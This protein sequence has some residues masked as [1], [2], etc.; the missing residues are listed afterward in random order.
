MSNLAGAVAKLGEREA[1]TTRL[2]EAVVIYQELLQ[3]YPGNGMPLVWA[4]TQ[5][6]FGTALTKLA[7]REGGT[8]RLV[9]ADRRLSRR[10][11]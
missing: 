5:N 9:E 4:A 2:Q 3:G 6:N 7:E 10:A 1:G 11:G 8:M